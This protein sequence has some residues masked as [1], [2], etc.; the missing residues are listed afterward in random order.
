MRTRVI[1]CLA[2]GT[3]FALPA[4][5]GAHALLVRSSVVTDLT[6][7][8]S[9][10][11]TLVDGGPGDT[12][13]GVNGV[14]ATADGTRSNGLTVNGSNQTSVGTPADPAGSDILSAGA[15]SV[16]NGTADP[17]HVVATVS[18]TDFT[19]ASLQAL[20]T[21]S[22]TFVSAPGGT[23]TL[24]YWN[25]PANAQGAETVSDTPGTPID[26]YSFTTTSGDQSFSH[27]SDP[28]AVSDAGPYSMTIQFDYTLPAGGSLISRGQAEIAPQV[29]IAE[30]GSLLLLG[31]GLLGAGVMTRR[32]HRKNSSPGVASSSY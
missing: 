30:P 23:I 29:R 19:P 1:T 8:G 27:D 24:R 25:D 26:T 16:V 11:G 9:T 22:G 20:T 28:F 3:G 21:G 2:I 14:I 10:S 4:P 7:G 15:S 5:Q 12:S 31:T 18:A 6:T 32:K 13:G 17:I